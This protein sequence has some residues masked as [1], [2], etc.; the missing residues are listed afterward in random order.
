[1][2]ATFNYDLVTEC[3]AKDSSEWK[4]GSP[5]YHL[6]WPAFSHKTKVSELKR[7]S[8]ATDVPILK[9]HGS[10]S[11]KVKQEFEFHDGGVLYQITTD[12]PMI[13]TPGNSKFS[14]AKKEL[15]LLWE[16][17]KEA[18]ETASAVVCLGYSFPPSDV[19]AL[20]TILEAIAA[21]KTSKC[22]VHVV[23]GHDAPAYNRLEAILDV[24]R[25]QNKEIEPIVRPLYVQ[26]FL[27]SAS[28]D[29]ILQRTSAAGA[30][31]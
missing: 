9:L 18:L 6:A 8:G 27:T 21:P 26:D 24:I 7:G 12:L 16:Y 23:L 17:A 15:S 25:Y 5:F 19:H 13:A 2:I 22:P 3:L 10:V 29:Y 31:P 28:R 4:S 20:S 14:Y 11:W 30:S 1:V